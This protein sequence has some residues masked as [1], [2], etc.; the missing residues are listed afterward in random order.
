MQFFFSSWGLEDFCRR[1]R[2]N[3]AGEGDRWMVGG[4]VKGEEGEGRVANRC[5]I[6]ILSFFLCGELKLEKICFTAVLDLNTNRRLL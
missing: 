5:V 1:R 2:R 6:L 4:W 3:L